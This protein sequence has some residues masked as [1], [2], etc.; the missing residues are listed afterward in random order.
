MI[1]TEEAGKILGVI[2]RRVRVLCA[3]GRIPGAQ[4]IGNS[5]MCP[6]NPKVIEA[7]HPRPSKI[8]MTKRKKVKA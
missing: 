5:W 2:A 1:G 8:A 3:Q 7:K 6:N 4:R